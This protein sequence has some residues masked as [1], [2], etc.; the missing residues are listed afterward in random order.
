MNKRLPWDEI[1]TPQN[2]LSVRAIKGS[3]GLPIYWG[4]DS[5]DHN[6]FVLELDG[7]HS[8]A[9]LKNIVSVKGIRTDL[10][11]IST[12]ENQGLII[13][14]ENKVDQDLFYSLC[15]SM[16]Q[17]L[18]NVTDPAVG[19]IVALNQI[20]RWKSFL[21]GKNSKLLTPEE[22]RGL[23]GELLFLRSMLL[24]GFSD[25]DAV[26]SWQGPENSHHDFNFS[27]T[28]VEIKT[29]SGKERRAVHISSED[30]L[31][32]LCE[33]LFLQIFRLIEKT[34]DK[35]SMS[36]NCLAR[37]LENT[38]QT[39]SAKEAFTRKLAEAGYLELEEYDQPELRLVEENTYRVSNNF[40]RLIR[41]K[42]P[43]GI[44]RINY[45]IKIEAIEDF[46]C[47]FEEIWE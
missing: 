40:P 32:G 46:K 10:R 18:E 29:L 23:F 19:I 21:A 42:L 44:I 34:D 14:L 13:T 27:N 3:Q 39:H 38:I 11:K 8:E 9:Y 12:N 31:E 7:N 2:D 17:S 22:I 20:K 6:I 28:S 47:N 15:R 24:K 25:N 45:E 36:L 35:E 5:F 1:K 26:N 4:K 43:N 41:S 16:I 37:E 30:Q 33:N